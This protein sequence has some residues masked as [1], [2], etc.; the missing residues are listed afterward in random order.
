MF[1]RLLMTLTA[2]FIS[3][4]A[5]AVTQAPPEGGSWYYEIGGAQS[6]SLPA[7]IS[8]TSTPISASANW[9]IGYSCGK[10]DP[11]LGVSSVLNDIKSGADAFLSNMISAATSSIASLPALI[12]QRANPGLYDLFQGGLLAAQE[13]VTLATKSCQQMEQEIAQG[14]NPY[15]EWATLA[16]GKDWKVQM[17]TGGS[18]SSSTSVIA[19]KKTIEN[20]GGKNGVD[21]I[22]GARG[23]VGQP[24]IKIPSDLAKAGYNI[25]MNRVAYAAGIPPGT[26]RVKELWGS[27]EAARD[28]SIAMLGDEEIQTFDGHVNKTIPGKGLLYFIGNEKVAMKALLAPMV[29]N[30]GTATVANLEAVAAPGTRLTKE[31]IEAMNNLGVAERSIFVDKLSEEIAMSRL[32]EKALHLRRMITMG[33]AHPDVEHTPAQAKLGKYLDKINTQ[34]ESVLFEK[35]IRKELVGATVP[36]LLGLAKK[37]KAA[38]LLITAPASNDKREMVGGAIKP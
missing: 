30:P 20:N 17:G 32:V 36:T 13:Q 6:I 31:A 23:G 3:I 21:W 28:F 33:A 16:V 38:G 34:I 5:S 10:F 35:R 14:I 27:V 2:L 25:A 37:R 26:G 4:S 11:I 7:N 24:P 8:Q 29:A 12:L 18:G 19:A 22:G 9:G 15:E 1:L